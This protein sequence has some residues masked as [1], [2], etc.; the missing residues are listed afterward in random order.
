MGDNN[1]TPK[2][3]N[4]YVKRTRY[5]VAKLAIGLIF[6][7]SITGIVLGILM[8]DL[9]TIVGS[10]ITAGITG[11]GTVAGVYIG[12]D[13]YRPSYFP[14]QPDNTVVIQQGVGNQNQQQL[15]KA[16]NAA[17]YPPTSEEALP[18]PPYIES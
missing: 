13:S 7:L 12:G 14:P 11:I 10:S 1:G 9:I 6:L 3:G 18:P 17:P 2:N 16:P 4:G 8:G 15:G 5:K